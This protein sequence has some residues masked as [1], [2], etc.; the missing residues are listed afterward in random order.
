VMGGPTRRRRTS[1]RT[2]LELIVLLG[3]ALLLF[4]GFVL[5]PI[6]VAVYYSFYSYHGFGPLTDYVGLRN[7]TPRSP[8]RPSGTRS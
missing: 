3:P 7:Y 1:L 2:R 8:I 6:V 4:A 5:A